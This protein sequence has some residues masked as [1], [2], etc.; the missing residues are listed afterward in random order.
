MPATKTPPAAEDQREALEDSER[1]AAK[2]Q[3]KGYRDEAED[4]IVE[5]PPI[6]GTDDQ[7]IRGLDP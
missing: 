7:P 6:A 1:E 5:I 3:P 4:K 2:T